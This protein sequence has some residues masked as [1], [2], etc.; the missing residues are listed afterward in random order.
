MASSDPATV[1]R[2]VDISPQVKACVRIAKR[3]RST[4]A[5]MEDVPTADVA[6]SKAAALRTILRPQATTPLP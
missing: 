3:V 1:T 4:A 5:E 2:T 6:R